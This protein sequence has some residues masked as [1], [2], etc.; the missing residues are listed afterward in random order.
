MSIQITS[1]NGSG[2]IARDG[3]FAYSYSEEVTSLS[4]SES[5][6]GVSQV[7]IS[8]IAADKSELLINNS[9]TMTDSERGSVAFSISNVSINEGAVNLTGKTL[10]ARLAVLRTAGP[11]GGDELAPMSLKDAIDYYCGLVNVTPIYDGTLG[12]DIDLIPVNFIGW[13]GNVWDYLK[14]LCS[15]VSASLVDNVPFEMYIASDGLH[16]RYAMDRVASISKSAKSLSIDSTESA[17]SV[18]VYNYNTSWGTDQV[19]YELSNFDP[20]TPVKDRF[21][22]SIR[23]SIQVDAGETVTRRYTINASLSSVNQPVCAAAIDR[24]PPSP[25]ADG[26]TGQYVIVGVEDL[27]ID[28]DEWNDLGGKLT[29]SLTE[30]PNE[31]EVTITAPPVQQLYQNGST[32]NF[33][34]APYKIGLEDEYPAFWI[35]GT[36]VFY[37]KVENT[38]LTGASNSYTSD[39][40]A[41]TVD[42]PFI[43]N[44]HDLSCRGVAAAQVACGPK[45]SVSGSAAVAETFGNMIG[46]TEYIGDNRFRYESVSYSPDGISFTGRAYSTVTDFNNTWDA[47]TFA[48]FAAVRSGVKF[49]DFTVQPLKG[50]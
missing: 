25:Y 39:L 47:K 10:M 24:I 43:T 4:P 49:S 9:V 12:A 1:N 8:A 30:N 18:A 42:N 6:G 40:E 2:N 38:L 16:F 26:G 34:N 45:V 46:L 48:E 50:A 29:V 13:T 11:V 37:E 27:P 5:N 21:Q 41:P 28:P 36:G 7:S 17:Q 20:T 22:S 33:G 23:D 3:I 44:Q 32:T 35:T 15:G 19:V 14:M 31:I